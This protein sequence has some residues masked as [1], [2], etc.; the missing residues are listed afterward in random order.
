MLDMSPT[1]TTSLKLASDFNA[2]QW[3]EKRGNLLLTIRNEQIILQLLK[4]D[5]VLLFGKPVN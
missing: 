5:F 3:I 2:T 1:E 4:S